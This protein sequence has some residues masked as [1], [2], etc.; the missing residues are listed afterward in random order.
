MLFL[1]QFIQVIECAALLNLRL[2]RILF[3]LFDYGV[4]FHLSVELRWYSWVLEVTVVLI[5]IVIDDV[6][7]E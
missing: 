6:L 3:F 2:L 7:N 4:Y 5:A 1:Y